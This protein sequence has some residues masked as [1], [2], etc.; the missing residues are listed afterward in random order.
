MSQ[1]IE[2]EFKNMLTKKEYERL[3]KE[4]N[5]DETQIFSQENHY[6]DTPDFAL[7][8]LGAALRIR[9]KDGAYEMTLKQ[10]AAVGLLETNQNLTADETS[11]AVKLGSLPAGI[12]QKL[13]E[14]NGIPFSKMEYFGSLVTHRV[15]IDYKNGVLVFDHSSYL[16]MEDYELEFEVEDY[17]AGLKFF[18]DLLAQFMIPERKTENKIHRFYYQKFKQHE[19]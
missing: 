2:I 14:E 19:I 6:F 13:I 9:K 5:I 18:K 3:L 11:L 15:E 16:G 1:N 12:V 10:P 7:K 17:Q 4:F 8:S